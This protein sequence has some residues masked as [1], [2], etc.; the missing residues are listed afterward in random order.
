MR[1]MHVQ[2]K[3][4]LTVVAVHTVRIYH[5]IIC[6]SFQ[7]SDSSVALNNSLV[8][9]HVTVQCQSN[10]VST[11]QWLVGYSITG[12]TGGEKREAIGSSSVSWRVV[13]VSNVVTHSHVVLW[14]NLT[15]QTVLPNLCL[16]EHCPPVCS[17]SRNLRSKLY[18]EHDQE[19]TIDMI[20]TTFET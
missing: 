3:V 6:L 19:Y 4:R 13:P 15:P 16:T 18:Y 10:L 2:Q 20:Q 7:S 9:G 8:A 11:F 14:L 17:S 12:I 1:Y 5:K